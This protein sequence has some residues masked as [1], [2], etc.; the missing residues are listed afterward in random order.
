MCSLIKCFE[1]TTSSFLY[2]FSEVEID[3]TGLKHSRLTFLDLKQPHSMPL[4]M[5]KR[6]PQKSTFSKHSVRFHVGRED[7]SHCM[8]KVIGNIL[9]F[10]F[11][12]LYLRLVFN[13]DHKNCSFLIYVFISI[14]LHSVLLC[15]LG[16]PGTHYVDQAGL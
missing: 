5:C 2:F 7:E 9:G 10:R 1:E 16:W 14:S 4:I 11:N 3:W 15:S 6:W 12:S 13:D 8:V